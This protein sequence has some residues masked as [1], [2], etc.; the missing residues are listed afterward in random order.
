MRADSDDYGDPYDPE[1]PYVRE[2]DDPLVQKD[3]NKRYPY[4]VI[5]VNGDY[6]LVSDP[7]FHW[8]VQCISTGAWYTE[9]SGG[10]CDDSQTREQYLKLV[11]EYF[12]EHEE[13][14]IL[15]CKECDAII[16]PGDFPLY[17]D[18][19]IT[20]CIDCYLIGVEGETHGS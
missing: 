16:D 8:H 14:T 6:R 7:E 12:P 13:A 19:T 2:E 1:S 4:E 11:K 17:F 5:A 3:L 10:L 9:A 20:L 15:H 18:D